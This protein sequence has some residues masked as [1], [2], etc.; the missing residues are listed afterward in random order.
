[1]QP[2]G[3]PCSSM[4]V[5]NSLLLLLLTVSIDVTFGS[6]PW[7][8]WHSPLRSLAMARDPSSNLTTLYPRFDYIVGRSIH[9]YGSYS[10]AELHLLAR[11]E[12][13]RTTVVEVGAHI[14]ALSAAMSQAVG[15]FGV[16][17]SVEPNPYFAD[18]AAAN[19]ALNSNARAVVL[20]SAASNISK[21]QCLRSA[22]LDKWQASAA[23]RDATACVSSPTA[24]T[25]RSRTLRPTVSVGSLP[26][27]KHR[28]ACGVTLAQAQGQECALAATG[29]AA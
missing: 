20:L 11:P 18:M 16:V 7:L 4:A 29:V 5:P 27:V 15:D 1:M 2:S 8:R 21:M 12:F 22:A 9:M 14:G 10:P 13:L 19:I 23:R 24:S 6:S 17:V 25:C 26:P 3:P 28:Q